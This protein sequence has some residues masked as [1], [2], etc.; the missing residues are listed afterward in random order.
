MRALRSGAAALLLFTGG[1]ACAAVMPPDEAALKS[2]QKPFPH[3]E[4]DALLKKYVDGKGRVDYG[5]LQA[6]A[7]DVQKLEQLYAAVAATSP[8]THPELYPSKGAKLAYYLN[9]YNVLVWKNV[10]HRIP[11]LT[12]VDK[13]KVSFFYSTDFIVG[14]EKHNLVDLENKL[15]RPMFND[16]RVHMALNC[17]SGGCPQ[18]PPEAFTPDKVDAQ[19]SREARKFVNEE[20]NVRYD[21]DKKTVYLSHIF[22]WYKGDFGKEPAKVLD[23]INHYRD[24]DKKLPTD[25]KLEYVDYDWTL[26]DVKLLKR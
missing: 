18:L 11:K 8:K 12:N 15:I 21:A 1:L 25:V 13:E 16:A 2:A 19:L 10:L 5:R 9:A 22:D 26:N 17:A 4:W 24:A 6:D 20:R 14:G 3:K 23:W 7:A